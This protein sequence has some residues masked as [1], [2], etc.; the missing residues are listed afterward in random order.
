MNIIKRYVVIE[1]GFF[2]CRYLE[3]IQII[4]RDNPFYFGSDSVFSL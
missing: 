4:T 3:I 1:L 2:L